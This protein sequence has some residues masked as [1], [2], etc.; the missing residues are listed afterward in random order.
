MTTSY[1]SATGNYSYTAQFAEGVEV[2]YSYV[3]KDPFAE[4]IAVAYSY[5]DGSTGV[6]PVVG[7]RAAYT[8]Q[9]MN[10]MPEWMDIRQK[11]DS[12]GQKV[13]HSW[14]ANLEDA[15]ELLAQHQLDSFLSTADPY[16]DIHMS[17]TELS[18]SEDKVY[19]PDLR[20]LLFNSSFSMKSFARSQKPEGWAVGRD[21]LD[22]LTFTED[23][24]IY[25]PHALRLINGVELS[26]SR[27]L[28]VA[29][30]DI[31]F[32][33]Y[34]KTESD[35]QL[36]TTV[37]HEPSDAGIVLV[38]YYADHDIESYGV[39]FPKNTL[40]EW[41]RVGL[42]VSIPKSVHKFEVFITNRTSDA[43]I[44]DLPMLEGSK[45]IQS[46]TPSTEDVPIYS[47]SPF[48]SVGGVQLL[49]GSVDRS[50][51]KKVELFELAT[52]DEFEDICIP[53][54]ILPYSPLK[55]SSQSVNRALGRQVNFFEEVL[56]VSWTAEDG[57]ITE[58]SLTTPDKFGVVLP[59]DLY[60]NKN[61]VS[62]LDESL[63]DA[64]IKV[65]STTVVKDCL[66]IV[67]KETY[68]G[69]TS[70]Y[71]KFAKVNKINYEDT[72]IQSFF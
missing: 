65:K 9:I 21:S 1:I 25:G 56:P 32:S 67:T 38:L 28:R 72:R 53:T 37:K 7:G 19:T 60:K 17:I 15:S 8:Q 51:V 40:G 71:L 10:N 66:Y 68:A 23:H 47:D 13:M 36:K 27:E 16:S 45:R 20:N 22:N 34:A 61:G 49:C 70:Y 29:G 24:S 11:H 35:T 3:E 39:G 2:A 62:L 63:S 55:N 42:T 43:Y 69:K 59:R 6:I 54:R 57:K 46:W 30:G 50:S 58:G 64:N 41:A 31:T 52:Q 33:I 48:K 12:V 14:A 26:Q 44:I 18:F 5:T 4:H